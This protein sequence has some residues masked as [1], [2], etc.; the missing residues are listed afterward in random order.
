MPKPA[1][2]QLYGK[3]LPWVTS[4]THLGHELHENANMNHDCKC[5]RARFIDNSTTVRETF[6]FADQQQVLKA[7]QI[8]CCDLYGSMLWDLYSDQ[9][10][11]FYRSWNTCVKLSWDLPRSTHTLFVESFLS[12]GLPSVRQQ[13]LTRYVKFYQSFV[14]SSSREVAVV[15]R[16]VG[17]D[18]WIQSCSQEPALLVCLRM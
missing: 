8:Y 15:A 18:A 4:A 10:E 6:S 2:L 1:P 13:V 17:C 7:V 5:K 9:A 11:Q 16:T 12:C 14:F 3:E